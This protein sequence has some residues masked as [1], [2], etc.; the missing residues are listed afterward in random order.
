MVPGCL[1]LELALAEGFSQILQLHEESS[2]VSVPDIRE[3]SET[4]IDE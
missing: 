3:I 4:L 2:G 1:P